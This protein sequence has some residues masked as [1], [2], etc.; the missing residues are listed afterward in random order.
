MNRKQFLKLAAG[1]AGGVAGLPL[2]PLA[3]GS[4]ASE[5][6][7]RLLAQAEAVGD[8][9]S[10]WKLIRGQF[11][12]DPGWIFLNFGG[13]GSC[14]LPVLNALLEFTRAEESAPS[15]GHD[16]KPWQEVKAKLARALGK[17]CRKEDLGLIGGATEGV[18]VIVNGLPLK[19]GDEVITSTHEHVAVHSALLNRMQRD[20]VVIRLFEPDKVRVRVPYVGSVVGILARTTRAIGSS[21]LGSMYG[22]RFA[23]F[24]D[25]APAKGTPAAPARTCPHCGKT[26]DFFKPKRVNGVIER[27]CPNCD[28]VFP[29]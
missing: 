7:G 6:I 22:P 19:R 20:G 25:Q 13:L 12:L 15:A 1:L 11:V 27:H 4:S 16:E 8:D 24:G 5:P 29:E 3:A 28:W 21:S 2:M 26:I 10:Y 14:P 23:L 9:E 18:N 17:T